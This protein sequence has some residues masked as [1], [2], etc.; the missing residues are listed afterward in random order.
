[1]HWL[2][3]T[4]LAAYILGTSW[5]AERLAG[6]GQTVRDFFLG[7]RKLPWWAVCGS[8]VASEVSGV[9][10]VAIPAIAFARGGNYTYLMLATGVIL[11]RF[12][13]GYV[14]V[15]AFYRHEIY[16]PYEF[17]GQR[18]GPAVDRLSTALFFVGA[19]LAQGAR[20]FVAALVLTNITS[21]GIVWA[22][23]L[24]G[25][26]SVV[27]TWIGGT[28]SVVWTDVVQFAIICAGGL[29]ALDAG[30]WAVPGGVSE[31]ARLGGQADKF[32]LFDLSLDRN[33]S[34]TLWCGLFG[35]PFLTLASHGTDQMTA[36]RIFCCRDAGE[37][38]KAVLWSSVRQVLP[39]L[40]LTVGVGIYAYFQ[41]YPPGEK[42]AALLDRRAENV[43]PIF[44]KR[45]MPLGLKGLLFA[46]IFSAATAT[47][48]LSAMAQTALSSFYKPL[49]R[50]P[51]TEAHLVFVSRILVLVSA[52]GLCAAAAMCDRIQQYPDILQMALAM[53]GYTYGALLGMLLLALIP[54]GRDARGLVWGVPFSM[55][56]VFALSWQHHG[57]ARI[58]AVAA[59]AAVS[60]GGVPLLR[61]EYRKVLWVLAG[62]GLVL[63]AALALV[64]QGGLLHPFKVAWPW[65]FPIG[66]AVT[67]GL[68]VALGRKRLAA[69]EPASL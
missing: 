27:W 42:D 68:G 65:H 37:A 14:F 10:F 26:I 23:V 33:A 36:Q 39:L 17:M 1:M 24:L 32:V 22:I 46:A 12:V 43:L 11:A 19:F 50:K 59:A 48:T 57:W 45:A 38:R 16:S 5:L 62:A 40:M 63:A 47:S 13:I 25:A 55:L 29:V 9:T 49:L 8:I 69:R 64:P 53:A 31:I 7:G 3:W 60:A 20:L 41:H 28:A 67:L 56:L 18:L 52:V 35:M 51:A 66:T 61:G 34:Y 30:V 21:M 6:R 2:D 4:V 15:P 44:I 54:F 58:A